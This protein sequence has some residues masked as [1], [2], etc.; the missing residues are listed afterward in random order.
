[1]KNSTDGTGHREKL[2][3]PR[4]QNLDKTEIDTWYKLA[5]EYLVRNNVWLIIDN[6]EIDKKEEDLTR[7]LNEFLQHPDIQQNNSRIIITTEITPIQAVLEQKSNLAA[8][9][10]QT[11]N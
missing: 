1:M 11:E 5:A 10:A 4:A 6:H 9:A 8:F 3:G 7:L 2:D